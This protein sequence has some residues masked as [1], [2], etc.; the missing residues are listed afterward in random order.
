MTDAPSSRLSSG[1]RVLGVVLTLAI[2]ASIVAVLVASDLDRLQAA[3][4]AAGPWGP[5]VYVV[6]H[7]LV[8]LVPVPKNLLAVIA[9]AVFGVAAG[10]VVAWVGAMAAA[11]TGFWIAR[12]LGRRRV[13]AVA[14]PRIERAQQAL[15]E[16]GFLAVVVARL[17]PVVPF[18]LVNYG[19]GVSEVSRRDFVLGTALGVVP[20]TVAYVLVGGSAG[21]DATTIGLFGAAG[22]LLLVA[23][24]VL[25]RRLRRP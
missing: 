21:A 10:L 12:R 7:V 3:V 1:V 13:T 23:T 4:A 14:G 8:S 5:L 15:R 17:A 11:L 19:A 22:V 18:T 9:G 2:V 25:A 16:R 24:G 6:G 20:G